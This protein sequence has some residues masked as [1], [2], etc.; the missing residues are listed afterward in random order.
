MEVDH[1]G[2]NPSKGVAFHATNSPT[3]L[4]VREHLLAANGDSKGKR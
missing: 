1:C 4:D 2:R 3:I